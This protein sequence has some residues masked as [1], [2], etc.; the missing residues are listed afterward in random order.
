MCDRRLLAGLVITVFLGNTA[1][2]FADDAEVERLIDQ[3]IDVAEPGLGYSPTVSGGEFLPYQD[4]GHI[5]TLILGGARPE[6]SETLRKIVELG[7]EVVPMLLK[8]I[9]DNRQCKM[10]PVSG[11]MWM[12]FS[13]EYDFNRR[14]LGKAP[15]GVNSDDRGFAENQPDKHAVT[16]GDLCFVALGQI[17]NRSFEAVRYQ[18]SG[19]AVINSPTYSA[20]LRRAILAEW[21]GLTKERHRQRLVED[22]TTADH[23]NRRSGAY[24]RLAFYYPAEVEA[25]VLQELA[26]P[27]YDVFAVERLCREVL[28]KTADKAERRRKFDEFVRENGELASAGVIDYLFEDLETLEAN[29][30]GRIHP[31]ITEFAK[32]PRELLIEVFGKPLTVK[33]VDRPLVRPTEAYERARLI[34]ALTHDVSPKIADAVTKIFQENGNDGYF[35]SAC[36]RCLAN[37]GQGAFLIDQLRRAEESRTHTNDFHA[38]CIE[39]IATSREQAVRDKLWEMTQATKNADYFMA[40]LPAIGDRPELPELAE[41]I[42]ASLP[43]DSKQV[44]VLLMVIGHKTPDRAPAI[45]RSFVRSGNIQRIATMSNVLGNAK[46]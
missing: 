44:M 24:L 7:A 9:G 37:R 21:N 15:E 35:G 17:V 12:Q 43:D 16:V 11:F 41:K 27:T 14:T 19:G 25:L 34:G 18:P 32:Q 13:D 26:K 10:K 3:L 20:A 23:E 38:K 31:P 6:Q 1:H 36:L 42:L 39:A 33:A 28:Y 46:Q 22:F 40:A 29:E 30:D 4:T 45:F 8:H 2:A 5:G